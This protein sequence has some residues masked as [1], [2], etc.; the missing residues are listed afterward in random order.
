MKSLLERC[1]TFT[2]SLR[3]LYLRYTI[4]NLIAFDFIGFV[5]IWVEIINTEPLSDANV[6]FIALLS[7][8]NNLNAQRTL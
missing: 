1:F 3:Y 2:Q 7:M 5:F 6:L 8:L 4:C